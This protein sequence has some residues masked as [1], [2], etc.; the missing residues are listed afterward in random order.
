VAQL[1]QASIVGPSLIRLKDGRYRL[2]LQARADRR[3]ENVDGT[4]IISLISTDGIQW[5]VEP[6]IRIPHGSESDVDFQAGEPGVYLGLDDKYYMAYTGRQMGVNP[7][8]K[9]ELMHR[10]VF[11]VSDED[12]G[13]TWT[14]LNQYYADPQNINDFASSA[15]VNVVNGRYVIYYTGQRNIIRA[16]SQDG[17]TWVRQEVTFSAGHDSTMVKYDGT[18]YMFAKMPEALAYARN[19]DTR[20]DL[21]VMAISRDGVNWSNNYY[22]VVV[23]NADGSEVT[24]ENLQDPSAILV[25]DGSLRIFLN[26]DRGEGIY[27]IK[28]VSTLPKLAP[29]LVGD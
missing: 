3:N 10:V 13:L 2:Y 14:K 18:Y 16:T 9:E 24:A 5:D 6:G 26:N 23:E 29:D 12:D 4:N 27:S 19:P 28:P 1:E 11:A 17:L 7:E 20:L 22:Q 25:L 8:G 21:L 15:D